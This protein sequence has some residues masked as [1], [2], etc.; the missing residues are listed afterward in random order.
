ME[1]LNEHNDYLVEGANWSC[2]FLT[3]PA[4]SFA[5][6]KNVYTSPNNIIVNLFALIFER[7]RVVIADIADRDNA[8]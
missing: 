3:P 1:D 2:V 5:W 6:P 4:R 8:G 7:F